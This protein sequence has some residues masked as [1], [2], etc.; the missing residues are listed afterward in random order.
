M[1]RERRLN[2]DLRG[3]QVSDLTDHDNIRVLAQEI[4]ERDSKSETGLAIHVHLSQTIQL[5]LDRIFD[6]DDVAVYSVDAVEDAVLRGGLARTR[7]P[8]R[9]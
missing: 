9:K 7:R 5:V 6:G 1:A 8:S 4:L 2:C 3:L